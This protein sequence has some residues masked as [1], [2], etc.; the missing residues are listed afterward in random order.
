MIAHEDLISAGQGDKFLSELWISQKARRNLHGRGAV[1]F[2]LGLSYTCLSWTGEKNLTHRGLKKG[3]DRLPRP[4]SLQR[5]QLRAFRPQPTASG[6]ITGDG[7]VVVKDSRDN[8]CPVDLPLDKAQIYRFVRSF[9][10]SSFGRRPRQKRDHRT[11]EGME[12]CFLG[13]VCSTVR[14]LK[15]DR[16]SARSMKNAGE[17]RHSET[18]TQ[19]SQLCPFSGSP[20]DHLQVTL[21]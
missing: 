17:A 10:A 11:G 1:C 20:A 5:P 6:T 8:S 12:G 14:P 21:V 16:R 2:S 18:K 9:G 19:R 7:K 15:V 3:A 13:L 4:A